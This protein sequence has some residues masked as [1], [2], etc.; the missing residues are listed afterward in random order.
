MRP[1]NGLTWY[2]ETIFVGRFLHL[3]KHIKFHVFLDKNREILYFKKSVVKSA[4]SCFRRWGAKPQ[5]VLRY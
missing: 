1:P 5:I 4:I 3:Y 2:S